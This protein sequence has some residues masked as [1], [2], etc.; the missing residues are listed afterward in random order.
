[1]CHVSLG[2]LGRL[3]RRS[4]FK[5][6]IFSHESQRRYAKTFGFD[7]QNGGNGSGR[8]NSGFV[9]QSQAQVQ[10]NGA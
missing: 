8:E 6:K 4:N 5:I 7:L 10:R 3:K 1:M 2:L 9:F